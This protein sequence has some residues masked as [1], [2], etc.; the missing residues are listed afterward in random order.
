MDIKQTKEYNVGSES[1]AYV[2][3][4]LYEFYGVWEGVDSSSI[5]P[6]KSNNY[7]PLDT[8]KHP[9]HMPLG[10][11]SYESADNLGNT[12]VYFVSKHLIPE[13]ANTRGKLVLRVPDEP[14]QPIVH[15]WVVEDW[16]N[17]MK[18]DMWR[19]VAIPDC[20]MEDT[21]RVVWTHY[22]IEYEKVLKKSRCS[23]MKVDSICGE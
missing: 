6:E 3:G 9:I 13:G 5:Y 7:L 14:P 19:M 23:V 18:G 11:P 21:F 2:Y 4:Y 16:V 15:E 10:L 8:T 17:P 12:T 1:N 22:E 20:R